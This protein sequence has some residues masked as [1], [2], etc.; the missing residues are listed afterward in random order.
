MHEHG[1]AD[2]LMRQALTIAQERG[3]STIRKVV[4]GIGDLTGLFQEPLEEQLMHVAGHHGLTGIEFEFF[5]IKP[6]AFCRE[7]RK[8]IGQEP[9]CPFCGG[10]NIEITSGLDNTIKEVL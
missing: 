2:R 7:C 9:R 3:L 8:I 1:E 10:G 4:I 6:E 5:K